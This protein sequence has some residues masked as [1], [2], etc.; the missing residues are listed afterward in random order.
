MLWKGTLA[1]SNKAE[2]ECEYFARGPQEK[3]PVQKSINIQRSKTEW[4][5]VK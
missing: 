2:N 5:D 3:E 1:R 4:N